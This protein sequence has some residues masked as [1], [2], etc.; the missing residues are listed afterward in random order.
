MHYLALSMLL[1]L[2]LLT[3]QDEAAQPPSDSPETTARLVA[4]RPK[5]RP[6]EWFPVLFLI[7][8]GG[9]ATEYLGPPDDGIRQAEGMP[10]TETS[11]VWTT[12]SDEE[13][14]LLPDLTA[15]QWPR[16][17]ERQGY[18]HGL[19]ELPIRIYIP[20]K[21]APKALPG[22]AW[23]TFEIEGVFAGEEP[24]SFDLDRRVHFSKR[25]VVDIVH[26]TDS[27]ATDVTT[28]DPR[29]FTGWRGELPDWSVQDT[30]VHRKKDGAPLFVW[31]VVTIP[32]AVV[33]LTLGWVFVTKRL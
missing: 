17:V 25:V 6:G 26:P 29:L 27:E 15:V 4:A 19:L 2:F 16:T 18:E 10:Q 1:P 12:G 9:E 28:V 24:G 31:L 23:L 11:L 20:I 21:A 5:I 3:P 14:R 7:E 30:R 13:Y 32:V 33:A 22:E 8:L